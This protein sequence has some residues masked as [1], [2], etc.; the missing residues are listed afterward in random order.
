MA[1]MGAGV[2]GDFFEFFSPVFNIADSSI[3][4]GVLIIL[5]FQHRFFKEK[6]SIEMAHEQLGTE[7]ENEKKP[8]DTH[9][10]DF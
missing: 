4:V 8:S 7:E 1:A 10:P 2:G 5:I 6:D 3:F 9:S